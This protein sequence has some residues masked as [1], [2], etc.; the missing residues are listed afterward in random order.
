MP[1]TTTSECGTKL[2]QFIVRHKIRPS[3]IA[4]AA[5]CSRQHLLR[6]RKGTMDPTRRVM[7]AVA[8][9]CGF[10]L[11]R[12]VTV[13]ELFDFDEMPRRPV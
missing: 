11:G 3:A 9:A 13:N 8:A 2:E 5:G 1:R 10:V 4:R 7:A 12:T 6:L